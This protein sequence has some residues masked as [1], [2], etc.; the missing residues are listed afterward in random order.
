MTQG[1]ANQEKSLVAGINPCF[2]MM[3]LKHY[4][5]TPLFQMQWSF[6][7]NASMPALGQ[8]PHRQ[9]RKR[10]NAYTT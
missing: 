10:K 2:S 1:S 3:I 6:K 8:G 9:D 5:M 7:T 4:T